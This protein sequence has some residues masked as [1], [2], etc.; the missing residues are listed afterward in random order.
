MNG[1]LAAGSSDAPRGF[2]QVRHLQA[3]INLDSLEE[4]QIV[5]SEA[6]LCFFHRNCV[7]SFGKRLDFS[8]IIMIGMN[9]NCIYVLLSIQSL[10]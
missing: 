7:R 6:V 5:G 3:A 1:R 9:I 2:E 8:D 10:K 4:T